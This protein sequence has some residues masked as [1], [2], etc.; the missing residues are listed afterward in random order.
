MV[1]VQQMAV[2]RMVNKLLGKISL[3]PK[4]RQRRQQHNAPLRLRRPRVLAEPDSV[5]GGS[6][7]VAIYATC[8]AVFGTTCGADMGV[9]EPR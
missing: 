4:L 9:G 3:L 2:A 7:V 1:L 6:R 5:L 8:S